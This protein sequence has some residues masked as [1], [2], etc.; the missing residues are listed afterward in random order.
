MSRAIRSGA[1]TTLELELI[2]RLFPRQPLR[3]LAARLR[4]SEAAVLD[5]ARVMFERR[6]VRS[7]WT[8]A[9]DRQLGISYGVLPLAH[10][11]LVLARAQRDIQQRVAQLSQGL[12]SRPWTPADERML[13]RL[14]GGRPGV[15]LQVILRRPVADIEARATD[16]RLGRDKRVP[17]AGVRRMPR[18]TAADVRVLRRLYPAAEANAIARELGR[19]VSSVTN[20]ASQLGLQKG[21]ASRSATG[22]RNVGQRWR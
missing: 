15:A 18:W 11:A 20:K 12:E 16:L 8:P 6:R 3:R 2:R 13:K 17:G 1:W 5:R 22:R 7:P 10:L 21:A 4:R 9:E 19:S 14:Y